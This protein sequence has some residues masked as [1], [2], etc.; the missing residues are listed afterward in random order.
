MAKY[1]IENSGRLMEWHNGDPADYYPFTI[2]GDTVRVDPDQSGFT[3]AAGR[4]SMAFSL[5]YLL[6][7]KT[8]PV[9]ED[10]IQ[11]RNLSN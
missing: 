4:K 8:L 6:K 11:C 2:G 9:I 7:D 10:S 1:R 3:L 5:A